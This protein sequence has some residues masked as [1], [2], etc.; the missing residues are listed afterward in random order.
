MPPHMNMNVVYWAVALGVGVWLLVFVT[1]K[2]R[3]RRE[4]SHSLTVLGTVSQQW[5]TGHRAEN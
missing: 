5:L 3:S 1:R 2:M 4:R